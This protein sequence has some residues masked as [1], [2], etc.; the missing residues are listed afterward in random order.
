MTEQDNIV[1][2]S[3]VESFFGGVGE[4]QVAAP[5][6]K[7][8]E[9][10]DD[11]KEVKKPDS[12]FSFKTEDTE[13][14]INKLIDVDKDELAIKEDEDIII[15]SA[16]DSKPKTVSTD[17]NLN[18]AVSELIKEGLIFGFDGEEEI[19]SV[20]DLKELIQA[21]K[22]EWKKEA[23]E[24]ELD[25]VFSAL[26]EDL[27][28]A[29]D[30]VKN[31][32]R[33]LKSLFK[34]LAQTQDIKGFDVGTDQK[35]ITRTYLEYTKFGTPEEIEEQL[36]EW[37][38][39]D[40]LDKKAEQF[41][42]KLEKLQEK[43]VQEKLAEQ[44]EVKKY[45]KQLIKSYF[46]G[47][48]EALQDKN[49]NGITINRDEQAAIYEDLTA[50]NYVSSRTGQPINY[51]GKFLE[52]ITWDEPNYKML[53]EL[54]L[55]A[56]NPEKYR[57]KIR[58]SVKAS[59]AENTVRKLKTAQGGLKPTTTPVEEET[60]KFTIPKKSITRNSILRK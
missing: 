22:E 28:Y 52:H 40:L 12:N 1:N 59:E 42:P 35:E 30:Y 16:K 51:L 60:N 45:Q 18:S 58:A 38:D 56:K 10:E 15:P 20:E 2:E 25:E 3:Y 5:V 46:D 9:D 13:V 7:T 36:S 37:E 32:G 43:V 29:V 53:A 47:V 41:K 14:P 11:K 39:M 33:D 23:L 50:N 8:D 24:N 19:K 4:T 27:Q 57:E 48:T 26:P 49:L 54:T 44:E 21:N 31:G 55:F 6:T 17:S 34:V